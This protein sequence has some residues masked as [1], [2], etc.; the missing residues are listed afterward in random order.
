M[1]RL[2]PWNLNI[3]SF[4]ANAN[5]LRLIYKLIFLVTIIS[6]AQNIFT[7]VVLDIEYHH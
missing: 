4:S 5:Q 6:V 2:S 1:P 7:N 3:T